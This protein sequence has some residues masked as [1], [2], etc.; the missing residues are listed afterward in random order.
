[1]NTLELGSVKD[2]REARSQCLYNDE[3][4]KIQR[5]FLLIHPKTPAPASFGYCRFPF[6][7][8]FVFPLLLPLP[9]FRSPFSENL[10]DFLPALE[11]RE[12]PRL[13]LRSDF[14][15]GGRLEPELS[16]GRPRGCGVAG[17]FGLGFFPVQLFQHLAHQ[18][19]HCTSFEVL[20]CPASSRPRRRHS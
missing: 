6:D 10:T 3:L 2:G 5:L 15:M 11:E 8:D 17:R 16:R 4:G 14:R 9:P 13:E 12:L 1:M 18:S 19:S 7:F 20:V